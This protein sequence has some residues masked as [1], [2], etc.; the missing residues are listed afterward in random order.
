MSINKAAAALVCL[1]NLGLEHCKLSEKS[2]FLPS[3]SEKFSHILCSTAV[4]V[5]QEEDKQIFP[6]LFNLHHRSP[7]PHKLTRAII[8]PH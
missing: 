1:S 2:Y 5:S 3:Q 6:C 4:I 7:S 8:M